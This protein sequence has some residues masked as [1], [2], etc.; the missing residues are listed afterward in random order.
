LRQQVPILSGDDRADKPT[1]PGYTTVDDAG[2]DGDDTIH[3]PIQFYEVPNCVGVDIGFAPTIDDKD[4]P[5]TVD[6]VYNEF[7]QDWV[8]L[9][10]RYLGKTYVKEVTSVAA[11][12][13]TMTDVIREWV[14]EHWG[15]E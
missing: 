6:L 4:G 15:C 13:K 5:E 9:A 8:I 7:I 11:E 12:G 14:E 3:A 10:L 1:L 2:S